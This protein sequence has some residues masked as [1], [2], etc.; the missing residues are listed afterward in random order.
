MQTEMN[1]L[2]GCASLWFV[3]LSNLLSSFVGLYLCT[4]VYN[5]DVLQELME[6]DAVRGCLLHAYRV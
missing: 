5:M 4:S 1:Q 2:D 3:E 6:D